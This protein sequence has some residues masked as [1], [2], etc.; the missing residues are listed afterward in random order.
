MKKYIIVDD[1]GYEV[2]K[3][4]LSKSKAISEAKRM[5]YENEETYYVAVV[6]GE[7]KFIPA[8]PPP[9]GSVV[10]SEK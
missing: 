3:Q 4:Y 1:M 7:V 10:Y 6:V 5:A 2:G 8:P 9:R